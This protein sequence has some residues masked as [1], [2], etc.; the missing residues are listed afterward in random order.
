MEVKMRRFRFPLATA[1][2]AEAL[3]A[4]AQAEGGEGYA[5]YRTGI[6]VGYDFDIGPA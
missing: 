2:A 6:A 4:S 3:P 5:E 1:A